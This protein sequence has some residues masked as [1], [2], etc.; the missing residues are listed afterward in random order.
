MP[1]EPVPSCRQILIGLTYEKS[2]QM[3]RRVYD[4]LVLPTVT[5]GQE[6]EGPLCSP[7]SSPHITKMTHVQMAL[8]Q[9]LCRLKRS[10]TTANMFGK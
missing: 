7:V 10:I 5:Y 1:W 3:M 2:F 9:Q 4:A 8:L 6:V